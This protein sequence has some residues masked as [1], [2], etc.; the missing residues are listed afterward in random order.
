MVRKVRLMMVAMCV[1]LMAGAAACS[2]KA[3]VEEKDG[4]PEAQ[5]PTPVETVRLAYRDTADTGSAKISMTM[6][7]TGLRQDGGSNAPTSFEMTADGV[8]DFGNGDT[9]MTML[10]EPLG[11]M[12]VRSVSGTIYQRLPEQFTSQ[13]PGSRPWMSVDLD[14]MMREQYGAGMSGLGAGG[15]PSDQLEYLR[16]VSDSVERIGQ[17][18]VRGVSTVHYR[19]TMDLRKAAPEDPR[20]HRAFQEAR[21][22]LGTDT[23]PIEVWLDGENRVRRMEMTA[24][25]Q[26]PGGEDDGR[27]EITQ[28]YYDFGVP[29][30]VSPPPAKDTASMEELMSGMAEHNDAR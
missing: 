13:I 8:V 26:N 23:I 24:P 14:A 15:R 17:E 1:V 22:R 29:A 27:M 16:S 10:M 18:Q 3:S 4:E 12:K 19:A 7:G 11:E 25:V 6:T 30:K 5:K 20:T 2:D 21:R 28:E 9:R